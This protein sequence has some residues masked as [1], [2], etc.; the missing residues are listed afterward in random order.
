MA[1]GVDGILEGSAAL[2]GR[3]VEGEAAGAVDLAERLFDNVAYAVRLRDPALLGPDYRFEDTRVAGTIDGAFDNLFI[4][5]ILTA[6]RLAV[7]EQEMLGVSQS[8]TA[9]YDGSRWTLPLDLEI[10]RLRTGTELADP[11]LVDGTLRGTLVYTGRELLADDLA[12]RFPGLTADLALRGDIPAGSYQLAGSASG[13]DLALE[14]LGLID[15]EARSLRFALAPG[16]PWRFSADLSGRMTRIDNDTLADLTGGNLRFTGGLALGGN[17]PIVFDNAVL[18]SAKLNATLDGRIENGTTAVAG[19]GSHTDYGDFTVQAALDDSGPRAQLVFAEP[20]DGF[21]DVAVALSPIPEGFEIVTSGA[22]PLGPFD[23]TVNFY[24][25]PSGPSR[26]DIAELTVMDTQVAGALTLADGGVA[27]DLALAGGGVDGT[28]A[29]APRAGGQGFDVDLTA[30][31]ARFGSAVSIASADIDASGVVGGGSYTVTGSATASGLQYNNLYLAQFTADAQVVDG[32]GT[33][34]GALAGRRGSRFALQFDGEASTERVAV[35]LRGQYAGRDIRMP[36]RAVLARTAAGGWQLEPTQLDFAGGR[37]LASGRF[38][39]EEPAAFDLG[40]SDLPLSLVDV[41]GADL[42]LGGRI[43]GRLNYMTGPDGLPTGDARVKIDGLSRS[44]LVLTSRPVDLSLVAQLTPTR[45][46]ARAILDDPETGQAGRVQARISNLPGDGGLVDRLNRGALFAQLR[47][48]GPAAALWRLAALDAFDISGPLSVSANATG[49]LQDPQVRGSLSGDDLRLRSSLTGTDIRSLRARGRFSG[50]RLELASFRGTAPNGGAV[51]GSG[52]IDLSDIGGGRGPGIDLR[53]AAR[54]AEILEREGLG[55]TVTGPLRIVSNGFGGT[56]AGRLEVLEANW[57]LGGSEAVQRLP[58]IQVTEVNLPEDR[59]QLVG[60]S[61]P[62][63]FLID[64]SAPLGG[65]DVD[66][67]GLDSEWR[68]D[69]VLRGTPENPRIGGA[70]EVVRGSYSFAGTRF[71]LTR[72]NIDFDENEPVNPRLDLI[73]S[74]D[75]QGLAVDVVITGFAQQPEIEFRSTPALPEEELLARV[76]FGGSI[77]D[78]SATDALQLGAALAS[79]RGGGGGLD[80]INSLRTAIGLDRLRIVSADPA[81]DRGTAIALGKRLGR[82]IYVEII[83]DGQGYTAT[84]LE[85]QVTN[86]LA[87][88]ASVSTIG[89]E[90][91]AAEYRRDY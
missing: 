85:Y 69:I 87:L 80:P 81:L 76:L 3:G 63:R 25:S 55:A 44:G 86:W 58:D 46:D 15:A 50:S 41:A 60:S 24:S 40:L 91:V 5:H 53:I 77:T 34:S 30:D 7:G 52:T 84:E 68:G 6:S 45:L 31:N 23:G 8:G 38:G 13:N 10:D 88:L 79:L 14:N 2:R 29:L 67:L 65:I 61:S 74:S 39:G 1:P 32:Q 56:I 4:D 54:N 62:W 66:G 51:S 11:R 70:V 73:A 48:D 26:I 90:S 57:A 64:A 28:I 78:L 75:V 22:S 49:T 17:R 82:R 47:Y 35:A 71:E 12:V 42:G 16:Q 19:R 59:R 36:R 20:V 72:G 37:L 89:R 27:G 9:R 83:T 33:F 18:R 43:S 21:T